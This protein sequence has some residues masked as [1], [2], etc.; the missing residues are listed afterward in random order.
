LLAL[1]LL[2]ACSAA[3]DAARPPLRVPA[4][5]DALLEQL[6]RG[7]ARLEPASGARQASADDPPAQVLETARRLLDAAASTGDA[8]LAARAQ[9]LLDRVQGRDTNPDAL[10]LRAF[11]AQHRHDFHGA[12]ALLDRLV[13][14]DPRDADA[15][16]SRAQV[17]LVLGRL[18][19][20]RD[21]CA[22]LAFGIDGGDGML[23]AAALSLRRGKATIAA[24]LAERW[25]AGVAPADPRRRYALALRADA[26][27]RAGAADAD[28]W[29]RQA[30][31]LGT[32]DVR[33]LAA[34]SRHLRATARPAQ[35][36]ALL[37]GA[38]P[39]DGIALERAL[40][41]DAARLP[42]AAALRRAQARRYALAHQL[43]ATPELR[44]EA[45]FELT[46]QHRPAVALVLAGR[47]FRTQRDDMDE[48][49][50]RRAARAAGH[51]DVTA[52]LDAWTKALQILPAD[53]TVAP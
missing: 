27:S 13:A 26:A 10:R 52:R 3:V 35:A 11:A 23:C 50:L 46:L 43:G 38:P 22:A 48:A 31:A 32:G 7:Y 45:E 47:N 37:A 28:D 8:R 42:A 34:F 2:C 15:R 41:A 51:A 53:A 21:D 24:M 33:T 25:L 49:L 4:R 36:Y 30:L 14:R 1:L 9:G 18:D 40:A 6:P 16:L 29:Y 5:A 44:E 20:V 12:L 17:N 19:A 39:S